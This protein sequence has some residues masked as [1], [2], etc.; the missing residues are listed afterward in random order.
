MLRLTPDDYNLAD[1]LE[2]KGCNQCSWAGATT[3][4]PDTLAGVHWFA[5][6]PAPKRLRS[7][8]AQLAKRAE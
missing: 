7:L 4:P 1:L 2:R 8:L 6:S 3:Q 5:P